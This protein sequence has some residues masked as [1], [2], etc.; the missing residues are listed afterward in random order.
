MGTKMNQTIIEKKLI[1]KYLEK[2]KEVCAARGIK[3][4]AKDIAIKIANQRIAIMYR[5][6]YMYAK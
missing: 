1:V 4:N 3:P 5:I 6:G 2:E